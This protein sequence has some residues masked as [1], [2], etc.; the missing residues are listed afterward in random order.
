MFYRVV[1]CCL[2]SFPSTLLL[3]LTAGLGFANVTDPFWAGYSLVLGPAAS[4]PLGLG[5]DW[6]RRRDTFSLTTL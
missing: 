4:T 5:D 3:L 1:G 2:S 6:V